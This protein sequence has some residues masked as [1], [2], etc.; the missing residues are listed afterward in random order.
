MSFSHTL[1]FGAQLSERGTRFRIW[2]PSA[3]SV[4]LVIERAVPHAERSPDILPAEIQLERDREGFAESDELPLGAGTRYRYRIDGKLLVPDPASRAQPEDVHQASAVVDPHDYD[5]MNYRW[6][7]RPWEQ[8]VLYELHIGTFTP[9]GTYR[10]AIDKLDHL[11]DVGITAVELMPLSDFPGSRNWGYDGVLPF[12]PDSAYGTPNDLKELI[13]AC[14]GRGLM[15]FL[16]VVYNHF[17]PDGNYLGAYA[18]PFFTDAYETPWGAAI[19]FTRRPVREFFIHNAIYWLNEYR[20]DGLRLD[21]VHAIHDPSER[22][23]LVELADRVRAE[24]DPE[25]HVHLVLENDDNAARYLDQAA[26][27]NAQWDDDFHHTAHVLAS[28]ESVGYYADYADTPLRNLVRSLS[29]GFVYQGEP[30]PFRGGTPRGERSEHLPPSAF[31]RFVQNHDQIGN[32]AFG[33]RLTESADPER[34]EL[35]I[36]VQCL[37]PHIPMLFM[38]EEWGSIRPFRFFC[39]FGDQLAEAVREGRRREFAGFPEFRDPTARERIPDPNSA[40]TYTACKLDWETIGSPELGPDGGTEAGWPA[41]RRA[42]ER[43]ELYRR[44]FRIRAEYLREPVRS[45]RAE[46][47]ASAALSARYELENG[48]VWCLWA[49][50]GNEPVEVSSLGQAKPIVAVPTGSEIAPDEPPAEGVAAGPFSAE[51]SSATPFLAEPTSLA[52]YTVIAGILEA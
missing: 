33:D 28:G 35:L 22:H 23:I 49:N 37:T 25:R 4:E 43:M 41:Q 46:L 48:R 36:A 14:H 9:E 18:T 34:L 10:A 40:E 15:V 12:A 19:D 20:F 11:V 27:Y 13:D 31:V 1:P 52:G 16:D 51:A 45:S 17:G 42:W 50:F 32:R 24:I 47:L 44:L 39:D 8:A 2:A 26:L 21:A 7:G 6:V 29:E 38:G 30:S 3:E 5:W